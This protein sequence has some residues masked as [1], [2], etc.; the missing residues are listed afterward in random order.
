[1]LVS[2]ILV[3]VNLQNLFGANPMKNMLEVGE[4]AC[5]E[6]EM[7]G[8]VECA[9]VKSCAWQ[10]EYCLATSSPESHNLT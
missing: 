3:G 2:S 4:N 1:M 10:L 6:Y 5:S 8:I 9:R 7:C